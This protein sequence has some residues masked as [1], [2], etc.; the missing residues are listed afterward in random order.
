MITGL[1]IKM[2]KPHEKLSMLAAKTFFKMSTEQLT[3]CIEE[4]FFTSLMTKNKTYKTTFHGRFSKVNP[5]IVEYIRDYGIRAPRILD[6]G[7]SSGI[8]T[9]ELYDDLEK[10]GI[11]PK[12]IATD[13]LI[14]AFLVK[15]LP[16]CYALV[17]SGG[18]PLRFDAPFFTMK[19]WVTRSDY[20]NGM[21][22]FR[23]SINK[24]FTFKANRILRRSG[25]SCVKKVKLVTPRVLSNTDITVC[26][27]DISRYNSSYESSFDFI[28]A[29]NVLNKGYFS[30]DILTTMI[31][32]IGRY[33][34]K[35]HGSLFVVR[36]HDDC[37]NH[38]T[39]FN[40]SCNQKFKV[41]QKFGNG[42]E[43][44]D[45]ILRSVE[46]TE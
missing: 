15:V 16:S 41:V 34:K 22:I 29:A 21:F 45:L 30:N 11:K 3:P 39:L 44:E 27:D 43:I 26:G 28:R 38:G 14:D 7:I 2:N 18:F 19:P 10:G 1:T 36:T 4:E 13:I 20:Y 40:W 42:S 31:S 23:K 33:L 8:S 32:N 6:I 46:I 9:I 5:H 17:D 25:N 35:P 37:T 12:I 24:L